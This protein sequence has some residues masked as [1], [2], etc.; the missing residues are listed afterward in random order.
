M[1]AS[2]NIKVN[3]DF[4]AASKDLQKFGAVTEAEA[5][6]IERFTKSFKT[7][8]IDNFIDK[9]RR[10]GAAVKATQGDMKSMETQQKALQRQMESLI[11]RGMD[12]QD[13]AIKKLNAEYKR[14]DDQMKKNAQTQKGVEMTT[15]AA[16]VGIQAMAAATVALATAAVV[17][18]V[19]LGKMGDQLAKN[20]RVIGVNVETMQELAFAAERVG[21]PASSL[22]GLFR[23]LNRNIGDLQANTGTLTTFLN[24]SNPA[25]AEQL[26]NVSNSEE[27]FNILIDAVAEAPTQF[28]KAALAQ[29]AFGRSGQD[30]ILFANEGTEGIEAL[31]AEARRYGVI[32]EETTAKGEAFA[33]AQRNL[34]QA[35]I[36]ARAELADKLL[37]AFTKIIQGAAEFV[38]QG[39]NL[40]LIFEALSVIIPVVV[41]GLTAY[42]LI[43]KGAQLVQTFTTAVQALNLAMAANPA[44]AVVLA[45]TAL[46]VGLVALFKIMQ[47]KRIEEF[48][49]QFGETAEIAALTNEQFHELAKNF[50]N[51]EQGFLMISRSVGEI[52]TDKLASEVTRIADKFE[53]SEAVLIDMLQ[54]SEKLDESFKQQLQTIDSSIAARE[55]ELAIIDLMNVSIQEAILLSNE[56]VATRAAARAEA[57]AELEAIRERRR[58]E[59]EDTLQK[60]IDARIKAQQDY[61]DAIAESE[62]R[63]RLGLI[64]EEETTQASITAAR[65]YADA[66][67]AAGYDGANAVELGN[68]ALLQMV[69]ILKMA[70][71][72]ALD[73][74]T[75]LTRLN[76]LSLTEAQVYNQRITTYQKFLNER[77]NLAG[78][79][80]Q[81]RIEFLIAESERIK[82]LDTII[83]AE[84]IEI[85]REIQ[86]EITRLEQEQTDKRFTQGSEALTR[87]GNFATSLWGSINQI[88]NNQEQKELDMLQKKD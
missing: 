1:A 39:S 56:S 40:K 84:R 70:T 81:A 54:A 42:L 46:T 87:Y 28:E 82:E 22:D 5:K 16:T 73:P 50:N 10:A 65:K 41:A 17:S 64:T 3:S 62:T 11:R 74:A 24:K 21:L 86:E 48:N 77:A 55:E 13:E 31:R 66:L 67:I 15:K 2:I 25:L 83:G 71:G 72:E 35:T 9:N 8:Q 63:R 88:R 69:D 80:G 14:L 76:E 49:E 44:A 37:P 27:A 59:Q 78:V 58:L 7:E 19:E 23:K 85:Q 20:S 60:Q 68:Q 75:I 33:D 47:A 6:R 43:V 18:T 38:A 29:A 79:E 32:A 57:E 61:N 52:D 12:P 45:I 4:A 30:L 26:K 53:I 34:K 36:G 51:I